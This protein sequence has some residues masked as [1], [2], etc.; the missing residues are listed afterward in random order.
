MAPLVKLMVS[1]DAGTP[2][3]VQLVLLNQSLET[4][5]FQV[6]VAAEHQPTLSRTERQS[7]GNKIADLCLLRRFVRTI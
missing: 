6:N 5:P 4:E 1:V 7:R 2:T 3:G